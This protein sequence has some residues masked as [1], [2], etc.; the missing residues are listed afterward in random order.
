MVE[1][2]LEIGKKAE[3]QLAGVGGAPAES[4]EFAQR[5]AEFHGE[6]HSFLDRRLNQKLRRRLD[7]SDLLQETQLAALQR[8]PAYCQTPAIPFR[9][10]LLLTAK[11]QL[12]QAYRTH[13]ATEKRTLDREIAWSDCSSMLIA[14]GLAVSESTPSEHVGKEEIVALVNVAVDRMHDLDREILLMRS[15]ENRPYEEI[16][17]LLDTNPEAARQRY[18]RALIKL[19]TAMRELGLLERPS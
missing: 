10:W 3:P 11:Q 6:L 14:Q 12:I 18:G 17:I 16:A 13:L 19:R 5:F 9:V 8:Y 15:V 7:T 4:Q 1:P 2:H